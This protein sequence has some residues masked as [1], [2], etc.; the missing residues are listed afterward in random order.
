MKQTIK[1]ILTAV[2]VFFAFAQ[3]EAQVTFKPGIR[4]GVNLSHF[5]KGDYDTYNYYNG[6]YGSQQSISFDNKTGFYVAFIAELHLTKYYTLQP[7]VM[8]SNQ[9]SK[10][11]SSVGG[12]QTLDVSYINLGIVN[13]FTFNKFNIHLGPTI[14]VVVDNNFDTDNDI[15]LGFQLGAGYNITKNLALEARARRGVIPVVD[16]SDNHDNVVFSFGLAYTFDMK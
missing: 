13:K 3:V 2:I 6:Y 15:D 5:S 9:G 11:T 1:G 7:E 4:A 8:Y 10:V 14:E 16:Y 12:E